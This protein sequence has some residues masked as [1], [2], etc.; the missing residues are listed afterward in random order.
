MSKYSLDFLNIIV[1][2]KLDSL[3]L[4]YYSD[5]VLGMFSNM[6]IEALLMNKKVLRVQINNKVDLFKFNEINSPSINTF[7]ELSNC[8]SKIIN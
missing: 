7:D 2:K 4:C 6:L 8:I 5:Y 3:T 1:V